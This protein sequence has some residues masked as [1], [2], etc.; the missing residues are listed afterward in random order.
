MYLL[1]YHISVSSRIPY[2]KL[3]IKHNLELD[4][5][6]EM[7]GLMDGWTDNYKSLINLRSTYDFYKVW[8]LEQMHFF[9][10][11]ILL[12][13]KTKTFYKQNHCQEEYLRLL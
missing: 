11:R 8:G 2:H 6:Q 13:S 10:D 3:I 12:K 7:K 5:Q 1:L 9:T 4:E